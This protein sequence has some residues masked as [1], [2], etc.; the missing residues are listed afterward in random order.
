M[1]RKTAAA[2][3]DM[4]EAA[5]LRAVAIGDL[6]EPILIGNKNYWYRVAIDTAV[7]VIAGDEVSTNHG[8]KGTWRE[9]S[10]LYKDDPDS[11]YR[12]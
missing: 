2:Y 5:F 3:C 7:A 4:A 11:K 10:P 9:R 6:P 1:T 8:I 12:K